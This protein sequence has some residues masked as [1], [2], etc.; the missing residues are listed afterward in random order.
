[1]GMT[2]AETVLKEAKQIL[3]ELGIQLKFFFTLRREQSY[4]YM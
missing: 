4:A 2:A 1:M 3:D